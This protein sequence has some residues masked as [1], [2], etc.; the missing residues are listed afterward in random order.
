MPVSM[1]KSEVNFGSGFY[2]L[3]YLLLPYLISFL[4]MFLSIPQ[5]CCKVI[6]FFLNF[7][8]SLFIFRRFL[9]K[10]GKAA[11]GSLGKFL[12]FTVLGLVFYYTS[13]LAVNYLILLMRPDFINLNDAGIVS[14]MEK[15][16]IWIAVSSVVFAPLAEELLFRGLLFHTVYEKHPVFAWFLSAGAFSAAHIMGYIGSYDMFSLLLAF[17]QYLPAGFCLAYAYKSS[18]TIFAPILMH[19]IINLISITILL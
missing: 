4:G 5:W 2:I 17:L 12:R 11:L 13:S 6:L 8:I 7:I 14:L 9:L 10:N 3:S 18:G 15:G 16:G 1:S 19:T